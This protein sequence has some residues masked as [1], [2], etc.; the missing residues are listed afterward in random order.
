M[1]NCLRLIC[2]LVFF[3]VT[4]VPGIAEYRTTNFIVRASSQEWEKITGDYAE[5][6]RKELAILWLGK[7]LPDWG[8][9]CEIELIFQKYNGGG[10]SF[11]FKDKETQGFLMTAKGT[12]E[13]ILDSVVRHELVHTILA[14]HLGQPVPRWLDEGAACL[15]E[16]ED[17]RLNWEE[18]IVKCLKSGRC[19]GTKELFLLTEYPK[20]YEAMYAQGYS[21][22]SWLVMSCGHQN[23]VEF[24]DNAFETGSWN[25]AAKN[26]YNFDSL[27]DMQ[28]AWVDW[29]K[30]TPGP[31]R[32]QV[33]QCPNGRCPIP[34]R[35]RPD[36][37]PAN[38]TVPPPRS[39]PISPPAVASPLPVNP[40]INF[41]WKEYDKRQAILLEA[42]AKSK[43]NCEP[44]NLTEVNAKLNLILSKINEQPK[45][46]TP[47]PLPQDEQHVVIVADH[48]AP[49]WPR[50]AEAIQNCKKTYSGVRDT[51][52]PN[53][54]I[55]IH[56]KAV[57]YRN[58][59]PVRIVEGQ[60]NV[61]ALL[62][63]L[64]RGEPI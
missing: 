37:Q 34:C 52:L 30:N 55:G 58:S 47:T 33:G 60:Y 20:D 15:V 8:S 35:P 11:A 25:T 27:S 13:R 63:R 53:F 4:S 5:A 38:V 3:L 40:K 36:Y 1:K 10:T 23:L 51:I 7:E 46:P 17:E 50:L 57:V 21:M 48:N 24:M 41:D 42:I 29:V 16:H 6:Q 45:S 19:F 56:P 18:S 43:C 26:V 62:S 61:E 44:T 31:I 54:P 2:F 32:Y 28:N 14:S 9:P 59:V 64:S 49:Y 12:P 22:C 39:V